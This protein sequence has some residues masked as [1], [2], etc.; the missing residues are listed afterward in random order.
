MLDNC[1][2][3]EVFR[4]TASS[5]CCSSSIINLYVA[6]FTVPMFAGS[7]TV[8]ELSPSKSGTFLKLQ[9][10][11]VPDFLC[12]SA[13]LMHSRQSFMSASLKATSNP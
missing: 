12:D 6:A 11:I 13:D 4:S 3:G 5:I 9:V 1:R 7:S 2:G 10:K 8:P